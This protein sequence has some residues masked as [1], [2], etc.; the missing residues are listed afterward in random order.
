MQGLYL[1]IG[2]VHISNVSLSVYENKASNEGSSLHP[3]LT[4]QLPEEYLGAL[5][6]VTLG[7]LQ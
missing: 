6:N 2:V 3:L 1:R 5:V 4:L 7:E